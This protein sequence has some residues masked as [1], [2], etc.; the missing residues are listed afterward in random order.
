MLPIARCSS[1]SKRRKRKLCCTAASARACEPSRRRPNPHGSKNTHGCQAIVDL[2]I[3]KIKVATPKPTIAMWSSESK[4]R[5]RKLCCTTTSV[6]ACELRLSRRRHSP[7]YNKN[8]HGCQ[9]IVEFINHHMA[10]PIGPPRFRVA[11]VHSHPEDTKN[12]HHLTTTHRNLSSQTSPSNRQPGQLRHPQHRLG[13]PVD[14][15]NTLKSSMQYLTASTF[16]SAISQ[17]I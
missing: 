4:R 8:T 3:I 1:E 13:N 17:A 14:I 16:H 2:S 9:A 6:R 5:K 12:I 15:N 10:H 7:Y 11:S